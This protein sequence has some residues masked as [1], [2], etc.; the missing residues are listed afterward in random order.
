MTFRSEL[1]HFLS[2]W[3]LFMRRATKILSA[4]FFLTMAFV[5]SDQAQAQ[6]T[7]ELGP[8]VAIG[9]GRTSSMA[10]ANA[11]SEAWDIVA[12]MAEVI[13][14]GHE[15]IDFVVERAELV[16]SNTYILEFH[17]VI[18]FDPNPPGGGG[19]GGPGT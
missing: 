17:L 4:C 2:N 8:F 19:Q 12:V 10:E 14:D 15:I 11:W 5:G 13:P 9:V 1:F 6:S 16:T 3:R 7:Y 18:E